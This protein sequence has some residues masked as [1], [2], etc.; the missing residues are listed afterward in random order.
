MLES[1]YSNKR[2]ILKKAQ[3]YFLN[4]SSLI[5]KIGCELEFFLLEKNGQALENQELLADLICELK[6]NLTKNFSLIYQLEK[7]QGLSQI[8]IKTSFTPDLSRLCEELEAAKNFVKNF[9]E[10]KNLVASFASQPFTND[11]GSALQFNISL[12]EGEKNIFE[13]DEKILKKVA[14]SLLNKTNEMLIF[15]APKAED[16][17]RFSFETNRNLFKQG[18]FTAPVNLSFGADNRTCAIRIP[19]S[20]IGKRL[21]YRIAAADADLF[22]SIAAIILAVLAGIGEEAENFEQIHGNAFD[23]Q[24]CLKSFCKNLDEARV[25]FLREGNFLSSIFVRL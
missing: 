14:T 22:L 21:E 17:A 3:D 13:S 5:L 23:E 6:E 10:E 12:H 4:S 8:E 7:E 9:A 15:L 16:Y 25:V 24:Y 19:Q 11:C 2:E 1:L 20:K 18:K